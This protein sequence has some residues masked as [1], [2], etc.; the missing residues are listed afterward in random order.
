[1][2]QVRAR[3]LKQMA[4]WVRE[5]DPGRP[6]HYEGDHTCAY[7]DIYSRMYP[8][9]LETEAIGADTGVI[10]YLDSSEDAERVRSK[11]FLMCEYAHAMGNGPGGMDI[12]DDLAERYPR[13][14][15]ASSGSGVI[16]DC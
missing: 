6:V 10:F 2:R 8:N 5:R 15:G 7:T 4:D 3:N 11:P 12:Y 13:L 16:M 9:Y 1:M 14:H